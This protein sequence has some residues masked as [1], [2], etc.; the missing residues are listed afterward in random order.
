MSPLSTKSRHLIGKVQIFPIHGWT[1]PEI[2]LRGQGTRDFFFIIRQKWFIR[3]ICTFKATIVWRIKVN[4]PHR[5]NHKGTRTRMKKRRVIGGLCLDPTTC[6]RC[7]CYLQ[8]RFSTIYDITG[9]EFVQSQPFMSIVSR[10]LMRM[11]TV[12][13]NPNRVTFEIMLRNRC[14][15]RWWSKLFSW[16]TVRLLTEEIRL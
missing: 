13:T 3:R 4:E 9:K 1:L 8:L 15:M 16:R 10:K 11:T 12:K 5:K 6:H 7:V 2:T 14:L